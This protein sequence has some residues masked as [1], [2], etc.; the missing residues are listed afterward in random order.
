MSI[1]MNDLQRSKCHS[2]VGPKHA[3][4]RMNGGCSSAIPS[5][6]PRCRPVFGTL[7]A[8]LSLQQS[9]AEGLLAAELLAT[10]AAKR[11]VSGTEFNSRR[12]GYSS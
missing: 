8:D 2:G 10:S 3:K 12:F 4:L 9:V 1:P 6:L 7:I 11:T 5:Q